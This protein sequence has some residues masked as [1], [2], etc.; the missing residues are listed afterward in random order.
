VSQQAVEILLGKIIT[1]DETRARFFRS[2]EQTCQS[3]GLH[4]TE[5]E[6]DALS[7]IPVQV[8]RQ[9]AMKLDPR[10]IRATLGNHEAQL[11][12]SEMVRARV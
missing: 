12:R 8:I 4:L 5:V 10:I 3:L 7:K 11:V 6:M 9:I 2:P 1:D